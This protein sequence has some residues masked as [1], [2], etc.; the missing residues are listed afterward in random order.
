MK[1][2]TKE[3]ELKLKPIS[4]KQLFYKKNTKFDILRHENMR[5][6]YFEHSSTK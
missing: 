6:V 5:D 3:I 1:F 4:C 2:Y